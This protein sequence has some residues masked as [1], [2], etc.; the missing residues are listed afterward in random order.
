MS[1]SLLIFGLVYAGRPMVIKWANP[2]PTAS[3]RAGGLRQ[4]QGGRVGDRRQGGGRGGGGGGGR[5]RGRGGA[6]GGGGGGAGAGRGGKAKNPT[7]TAAEL[8][9]ELDAYVSANAK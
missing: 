2:P 6:R 1:Y 7:P 5:G 9:A 8:D 3:P 4:V